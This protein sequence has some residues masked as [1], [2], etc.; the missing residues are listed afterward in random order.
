MAA[1]IWLRTHDI[2]KGAACALFL[3]IRNL[4]SSLIDV[5]NEATVDVLCGICIFAVAVD[6]GDAISIFGV[7]FCVARS[8]SM[9]NARALNCGTSNKYRLLRFFFMPIKELCATPC[10]SREPV[11]LIHSLP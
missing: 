1:Y 11:A 2:R 7:G 9:G 3:T 4:A 10:H 8:T 5:K 6:S